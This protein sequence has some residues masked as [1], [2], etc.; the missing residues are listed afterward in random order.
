MKPRKILA[1][2]DQDDCCFKGD[3]GWFHMWIPGDLEM[4]DTQAIIEWDNG[5]CTEVPIWKFR[6][7]N[8][9]EGNKHGTET[10]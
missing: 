5:R 8:N 7:I 9:P 10:D 1:I 3:I 2:E 4:T 6:F